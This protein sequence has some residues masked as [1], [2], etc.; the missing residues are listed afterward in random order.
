MSN[1]IFYSGILT[2]CLLA[3][4]VILKFLKKQHKWHKWLGYTTATIA[5][6]HGGM[7]IY[8][9]IRLYILYS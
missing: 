7:A 2:F 9:T 5:L 4:T 6:F 8:K 3:L 1:F